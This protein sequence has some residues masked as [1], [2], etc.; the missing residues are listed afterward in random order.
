MPAMFQ[1]AFA[2][3]KSSIYESNSIGSLISEYLS[4]YLAV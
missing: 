2:Q 3:N 1:A 4:E